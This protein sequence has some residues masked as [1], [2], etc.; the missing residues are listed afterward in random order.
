[1]TAIV[2]HTEP[3]PDSYRW[4]PTNP[5]TG[6]NKFYV[7][8]AEELARQ[9]LV[10][11]VYDGPAKHING[12][13]YIPRGTDALDRERVVIDCNVDRP[14]HGARARFQW[15]SF[16]NRP[17]VCVGEGYDRLFLVSDFVWSTLAPFVK[18]PVSVVELG[19]DFAVVADPKLSA[20]GKFCCFTSAPDRGLGLLQAIWP[21]I[22]KETGYELLSTPYGAGADEGHVQAVL[23]ASRFWLHPCTGVEL[24]CISGVEAQA[25]GC[26]PFY[27]PHMAL[28]ETVR[29]GIPTDLHRF[30][31]DL[32][33][34]LATADDTAFTQ[35]EGERTRALASHP[36]PTWADTARTILSEIR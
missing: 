12:V 14:R 29:Y 19:C 13:M 11:V 26:V 31:N 16:Y 27:V 23:D 10:S 32:I 2:I 28:P 15:T 36:I 33:T 22:V 24:Y 18:A 21:E 8:T 30:K 25:R 17:D 3:L 35:F 7:R 9:G 20:R 6:T 4:D 5:I 1:M 34:V